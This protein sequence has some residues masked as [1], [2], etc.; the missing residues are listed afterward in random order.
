MYMMYTVVQCVNSQTTALY[1]LYAW[2]KHSDRKSPTLY[3][4]YWT[5]SKVLLNQSHYNNFF[6]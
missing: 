3:I 1:V 5:L 4:Q 2:I 6:F